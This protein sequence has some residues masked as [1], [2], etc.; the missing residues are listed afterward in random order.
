MAKPYQDLYGLPK[1]CMSTDLDA[2]ASATLAV[3]SDLIGAQY[4]A[5]AALLYTSSALK[6]STGFNIFG[7]TLGAATTG[8]RTL[9]FYA[10]KT[11]FTT[12]NVLLWTLALP[13]GAAA[14]NYYPIGGPRGRYWGTDISASIVG[15]GFAFIASDN[16]L[17][18]TIWWEPTSGT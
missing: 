11:D 18:G 7:F 6:N 15:G 12:Y 4:H 14:G 3:P 16:E 13:S 17:V 8:A 9:A 5:S 1:G 10:P 2:S